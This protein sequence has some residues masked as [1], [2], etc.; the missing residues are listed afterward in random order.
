MKVPHKLLGIGFLCLLLAGVWFTNA[1]FTKKFVDY[2]RVTLQTSRIGLQLPARADVKVRGVIV[3]EVLAFKPTASGAEI[4]LGIYPDDIDTIPK[5]VTGS[6]LPKTLFGEKYVS[7]DIPSAPDSTPIAV[8]DVIPRTD[9]SIEVEKVLADLYPLLT[10]VQPADLNRT[11]TAIATALE[12]RGEKIGSSLQTLDSYL[13]RINPQ[14]PALVDDLKLTTQVA[15]TYSDVMPQIAQILRNTVKTGH[16]LEGREAALHQFFKDVSSFSDT[17]T[18]FLDQNDDN[19]IRLGDLSKT[20]TDLFAK[21]APEYPCLLK[22]IVNSGKLEAAAFR[23]YVLHI[24]LEV[25]P[26]QPR[27]Y[28]P[29][30]TPRYGDK[31]GPNCIGLPNPSTSQQHPWT[32]VPNI[33][34]GVDEPTG[35]GTDRVAPGWGTGFVGGPQESMLLKGMLGPVLGVPAEDVDDLGVL[36]IGPMA[37]GAEVELR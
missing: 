17:A 28:T 35:K 10:T 9:V 27:G 8:G 14:I 7:L 6:I 29:K 34:D 16:T 30:D 32:D 36:L 24:N 26:S 19:I 3:G 5:N 21:Y 25:L 18:T 13:K 1:I 12:G 11:L 20:Q 33:N 37:R 23:G 31:R 22:G 2:D 15:G 4:T